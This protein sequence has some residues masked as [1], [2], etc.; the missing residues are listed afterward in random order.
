MKINK[1]DYSSHKE[2]VDYYAT[3]SLS[4]STNNRMRDTYD[5]IIRNLKNRHIGQKRDI[6]DIMDIGCGAGAMSMIWAQHGHIVHGLDINQ[7]LLAIARERATEAGLSIEFCLGSAT[8]LP[9]GN[10][11]MD[12]CIAPELLEHVVEWEACVKEFAR[13]LKPNGVLFISTSNKLC[14]KQ[15]EF[16]LPFYSWYP[17]ILKHHFENLAKTTRPD[18]A[19]YATYPAINWFS[20]YQLKKYLAALNLDTYDRFDIMDLNNKSALQKTIARLIRRIPALRWLAHT[21]SP[22]LS[23]LAIKKP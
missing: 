14:P 16:N 7:P 3:E 20:F 21:A 6:M 13:V 19:N 11:S 9:W 8:D 18:L 12:V 2:F 22:F 1:L 23:I 17:S 4:E 10:E 15:S 5:S